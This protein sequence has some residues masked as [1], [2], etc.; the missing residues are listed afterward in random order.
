MDAVKDAVGGDSQWPVMFNQDEGTF[1]T[2]IAAGDTGN[3]HVVMYPCRG[4]EQMNIAFAVPDWSLKRP[5]ELE[6]SWNA[7][8]S[9]PEMVEGIQGFPPW[10]QRVFSRTPRV[11]LFQ[12]HGQEPLPTYVKSRTILIGDAAHAMVPYQ[13]QGANQALE[14]VEGINALFADILD[15]DNIP[16]LLQNWD[17]ISS[18]PCIRDSKGFSHFSG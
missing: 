1:V 17:S 4:H 2:V 11:A 15:R 5:S 9:V 18:T 14:D 7:Q 13:G 8:G 6:Y 16:S 3:R 10:L 12:V